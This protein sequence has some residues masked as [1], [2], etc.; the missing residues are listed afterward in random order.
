MPAP[1]RRIALGFENF[2]VL[3]PL[4]RKSLYFAYGN[5]TWAISIYH[6]IYRARNMCLFPFPKKNRNILIKHG[7][8]KSSLS[9]LSTSCSENSRLDKYLSYSLEHTSVQIVKNH[10]HH[11]GPLWEMLWYEQCT[12]GG[13]TCGGCGFS[14]CGAG[15]GGGCY[16]STRPARSRRRN[17]ACN[18]QSHRYASKRVHCFFASGSWRGTYGGLCDVG[19]HVLGSGRIQ[20]LWLL[21][22]M[23]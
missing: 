12:T 21:I 19:V 13:R 4:L 10:L 22:V 15:V 9:S 14:F 20:K 5:D 1:P 17:A 2:H 23:V 7:Y 11:E 6:W 3:T 16:E 18:R 8:R